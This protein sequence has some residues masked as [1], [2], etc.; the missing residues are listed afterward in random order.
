MENGVVAADIAQGIADGLLALHGPDRYFNIQNLR[1]ATHLLV[2]ALALAD[3]TPPDGFWS[4]ID[5]GWPVNTMEL[6]LYAIERS[7]KKVAVY[8]SGVPKG[9]DE[10][11]F[12]GNFAWDNETAYHPLV[13]A[14]EASSGFSDATA[15]M[16]GA[17]VQSF[18]AALLHAELNQL[19]SALADPALDVVEV[20]R[21]LTDAVN[22]LAG[23]IFAKTDLLR[24]ID[25]L[26]WGAAPTWAGAKAQDARRFV[27][28]IGLLSTAILNRLL[29]SSPTLTPEYENKLRD[30]ATTL[31]QLDGLADRGVALF[32]HVASTALAPVQEQLQVAQAQ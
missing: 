27:N 29:A 21:A 19:A 14:L 16:V 10:A 4:A 3:Q 7:G 23:A 28:V 32:A 30:V 17:R 20:K 5:L 13:N 22:A 18:D 2:N 11:F 8:F 31:A 12:R 25:V 9:Y 1:Q 6:A 15:S 26:W 24:L